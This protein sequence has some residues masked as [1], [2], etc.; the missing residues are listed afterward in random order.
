[1]DSGLVGR[2]A[3]C[4]HCQQASRNL[5]REKEGEV[6]AFLAHLRLRM[7]S[8]GHLLGYCKTVK[9]G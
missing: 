3:V 2:L 1:M 7:T 6:L 8:A 5:K 4:S 9:P